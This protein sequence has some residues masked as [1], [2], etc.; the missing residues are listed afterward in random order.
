MRLIDVLG[1]QQRVLMAVGFSLL[2]LVPAIYQL[3]LWM[4]RD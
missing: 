1:S 4:K 2:I 3:H